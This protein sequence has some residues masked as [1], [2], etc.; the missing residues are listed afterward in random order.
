MVMALSFASCRTNQPAYKTFAV[1][2][3]DIYCLSNPGDGTVTLMAWGTGA[4]RAEAIDNAIR[5]AVRQILFKGVKMGPGAAGAAIQ[6][7]VTEVNAQER[8]A[9]YFEPFFSRGGLYLAFGSESTTN[10]GSRTE[11]KSAGRQ[12]D[13]IVVV[14]NRSALRQ[15][16]IDDG[17]LKP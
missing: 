11:T 5:Q 17:I 3:A 1:T 16:L 13:G 8:Y 14:V 12:G 7:L 9:Y 6:P 10:K 15:R 2:G 4:N